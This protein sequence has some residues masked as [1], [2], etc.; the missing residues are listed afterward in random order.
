MMGSRS[1]R[2]SWKDLI[3]YPHVLRELELPDETRASDEGRD[4]AFR[5][6]IQRAFRKGRAICAPAANHPAAAHIRGRVTW[7]H[8][9]HVRAQGN[10][11][12]VRVHLRIV[13]IVVPL[14]IGAELRVVFFGREHQGSAAAPAAHQFRRYQFLLFVCIAVLLAGTGG[15]GRRAPR[16]AY[17]RGNCH[18]ETRSQ[19]AATGQS[20]RPRRCSQGKTLPA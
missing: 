16:G 5:S 19:G 2:S 10:R 7:I 1:F 9:A 18:Y 6:V 15:N 14:R 8:A 3:V 17:R 13:E 20:R 11:I 12:T 4:A